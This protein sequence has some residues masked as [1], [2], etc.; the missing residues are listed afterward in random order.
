MPNQDDTPTRQ[1]IFTEKAPRPAGAYSQAIRYGNLVFTAGIIG[2]DPQTGKLV[3]PGDTAAQT[4]QALR[5]LA[6]ILRAS[7]SS[8]AHALKV[9][10]FLADVK[11]WPAFNAAYS[12]FF[13]EGPPARS[14]IEIGHLPPGVMVEI[15]VI[16]AVAP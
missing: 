10:A 9:T 16:A 5:N 3:A 12:R 2:N 8:L 4:E 1:V 14:A 7:G 11:E 13:S 15:E 6:E